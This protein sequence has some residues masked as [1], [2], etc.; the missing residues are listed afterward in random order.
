MIR[1]ANV[2]FRDGV[3]IPEIAEEFGIEQ[4]ILYRHLKGHVNRTKDVVGG[5]NPKGFLNQ[6]QDFENFLNTR[7]SRTLAEKEKLKEEIL[8][9][10]D[11]DEEDDD[12]GREISKKAVDILFGKLEEKPKEEY[13]QTPTGKQPKFI[14]IEVNPKMLDNLI[15]KVPV[16]YRK[17]IK[18]GSISREIAVKFGVKQGLDAQIVNL[19]YD[20]IQNK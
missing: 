9:E 16:S 4:S 17:G 15:K 10:L 12:L 5:E 13:M 20:R 6:Y 19:L 1:L 8:A 7:T 11:T 2:R 18:N 3:T 14:Q